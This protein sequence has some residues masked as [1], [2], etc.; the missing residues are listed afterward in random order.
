MKKALLIIAV[1]TLVAV[2]SGMT[3]CEKQTSGEPGFNLIF[4][5]GVTAKNELDT[6]K[7]TYTK[8]MV[9]D[10]SFTVELRLSQEEMSRIHQKMV[11]IDFFSYPETFR[12]T[13][14]PGE[15]TGTVTP[16]SSYY[17]SVEYDSQ[18]KKLSWADDVTNP[19]EKASK[20][21]ALINLIK[22]IIESREEY[23]KLPAPSGG[24]L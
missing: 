19:D 12:V 10:P 5:Y 14:P 20:L 21:R 3:G 18:I 4:K 24:Y 16:F 6:F 23:K 13:V 11:E 1:L 9:T 22:S 17:F 2:L 7:G 15:L 8:D